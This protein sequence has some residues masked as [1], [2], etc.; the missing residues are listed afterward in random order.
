MSS[1]ANPLSS[2][3]AKPAALV[4]V[5]FLFVFLLQIVPHGHQNGQDEATCRICQVAH[6]GVALAVAVVSLN[7][8]L[9]T[10]GTVAA[11]T[12]AVSRSLFFT[13]SL[14]RAPPSLG[15]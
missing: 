5:C 13:H 14:S 1:P 12:V 2:R 3:F 10:L 7:V 9:A 15:L 6:L 11:L 4:L 8:P